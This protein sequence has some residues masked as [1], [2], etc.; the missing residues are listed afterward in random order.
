MPKADKPVFELHQKAEEDS[1]SK[2]EAIKNLIFGEQIEVYDAEF[3]KLKADIQAKKKVLDTLIEEVREELTSS[4][5]NLSTD[6]SIRITELEE[7]LEG[8]LED[9]ESATVNRKELGRLLV[10]LGER[11]AKK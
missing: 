11:V 4:I 9:L 3:E 8:K 10:D 1:T 7:N 5:D 6:L 2:I